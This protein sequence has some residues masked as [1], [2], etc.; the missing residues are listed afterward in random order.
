M[1][2]ARALVDRL[3][4]SDGDN[5]K[6][7]AAFEGIYLLEGVSKAVDAKRLPPPPDLPHPP[8][9][10]PIGAGDPPHSGGAVPPEDDRGH[11]PPLP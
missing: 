1:D 7:L 3:V 6:V 8:V 5:Q 9:A 4:E 2:K 10:H 11:L